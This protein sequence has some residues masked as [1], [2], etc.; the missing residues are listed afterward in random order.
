MQGAL[1]G[2]FDRSWGAMTAPEP[3]PTDQ[4]GK[5]AGALPEVAPG[6]SDPQI[7]SSLSRLDVP[8]RQRL[9]TRLIILIAGVSAATIGAFALLEFRIQQQLVEQV[10]HS[11]DLLS[12]TIKNSTRRAMLDDRRDEVYETMKEIGRGSGIER[13]RIL[14]KEG[15]ITFS[16]DGHEIGTLV[17]KRAEGCYGCHTSDRPLEQLAAGR[18]SR[19]FGGEGRRV[20]GMVTPI[21]NEPSCSTAACHVHEQARLLGVL[22]VSFSLSEIDRQTAR[23]RLNAIGLSAAA[24][25]FLAGVF[26]F[27]LRVH[28]VQPVA[29]LLQGTRRVAGDRLDQEVHVD[30][31]GELGLLAESFNEMTHTLRKAQDELRG[32][33]SGL[34][35]Q[36]EERTAAL[37]AAQDQLVRSEKLSSLGK[38]AASIAHEINNP[39]A[40]IL[41]FA[42]LIIRTLEHGSPDEPARKV[43]IKNLSLVQRETERCSAIV[44]NLLDFARER[45]LSLKEVSV[46]QAIEEVVSLLSNQIAIQGLTLEREL[47]TIP[48]VKAD[49]GQL[50]QTFVNITMNACEAM[51]CGGKLT[52]ASRSDGEWVEVAFTDTGPGIP[53]SALTKIFDPFFT[54]KEKGTGLGLSVV[55]GIVERHGGKLE[56]QSA[57]G[58]GTTMRVRLPV[59]P[60]GGSGRQADGP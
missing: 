34:E 6:P 60:G 46:N 49:F 47:G 23:F 19:V 9:S 8:W 33:N 7:L 13:V 24:V 35:S 45:P 26:F 10:T 54:T 48:L 5:P 55:Y 57:L 28:V 59:S 27:F 15:R 39:L 22:D 44:R 36:V 30:T 43:L 31:R 20:M 37:R 18:R 41:T 29:A 58:K 50:R 3:S 32:L 21:Y 42:K 25:L 11:A 4:D 53:Q 17:D 38:L 1:L 40:G 16:T 51:T 14:N 52:I 56:V 2:V 12:E